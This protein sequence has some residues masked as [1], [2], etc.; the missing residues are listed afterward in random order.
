MIYIL[1]KPYNQGLYEQ[2]IDVIN[3]TG[4]MLRTTCTE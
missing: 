3:R 2:W 1:D 4:L